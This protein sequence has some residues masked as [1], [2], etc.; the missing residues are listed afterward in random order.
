[1]LFRSKNSG[2]FFT[3][4]YVKENGENNI[5]DMVVKHGLITENNNRLLLCIWNGSQHSYVIINDDE[6]LN[7]NETFNKELKWED[8]KGKEEQAIKDHMTK[9]QER[10]DNIKKSF[11]EVTKKKTL[12]EIYHDFYGTQDWRI[13]GGDPLFPTRYEHRITIVP[14]NQTLLNEYRSGSHDGDSRHK[15]IYKAMLEGKHYEEIEIG[16]A[17]V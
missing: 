1:M 16:R 14:I 8:P 6:I 4:S 5:G 13:Y 12:E 2:G 17:H 7:K 11:K 10:H 3:T 9:I 15:K